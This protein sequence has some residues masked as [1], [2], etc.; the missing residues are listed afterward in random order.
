VY[1]LRVRKDSSTRLRIDPYHVPNTSLISN[2]YTVH[3]G[4]RHSSA[5]GTHQGRSTSG[6]GSGRAS[7]HPITCVAIAVS[8][9]TLPDGTGKDHTISP[10]GGLGKST[11]LLHKLESTRASE[12]AECGPGL[13]GT[14][15]SRSLSRPR[16]LAAPLAR[17]LIVTLHGP[18]LRRPEKPAR[19]I[20][21]YYCNRGSNEFLSHGIAARA[22][23]YSNKSSTRKF[24]KC[25]RLVRAPSPFF[26]RCRRRMLGPLCAGQGFFRPPPPWRHHHRDG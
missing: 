7:N 3:S 10:Q 11:Q 4:T 24:P 13:L 2:Q 22:L 8:F 19:Q 15:C 25:R 14:I 16:T 5:H 18:Q 23:H 1:P 20:P 12:F 21:A 9:G 6:A 17:L 26:A